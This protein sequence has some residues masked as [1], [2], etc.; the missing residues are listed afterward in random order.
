[1]DDNV[2]QGMPGMGGPSMPSVAGPGG[3][4]MPGMVPPPV[5]T[6]PPPPSS[7]GGG[8]I[9]EQHEKIMASLARIEEKLAAISAKVGA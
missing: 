9:E 4:G 2:N 6:M 7:S 3:L 1:M 5:G 8:P